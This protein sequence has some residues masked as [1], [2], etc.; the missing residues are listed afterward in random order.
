MSKIFNLILGLSI[1]MVVIIS[2]QVVLDAA[3]LG[4]EVN[5][6]EI[7]LS[8]VPL[9]EKIV[10]SKA[11]N[12]R[13]KLEIENKSTLACVYKIDILPASQTSAVIER[14]YTDI[15]DTSWIWPQEKEVMVQAKSTEEVELFLK[16]PDEE[17]YKGKNF[18]AV[19]EVKSK[20][21]SPEEIFV[22][23]VQLKIFFST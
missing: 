5:P 22:V 9:G 13:T 17:N 8:D 19:I 23:A 10:V 7:T 1:M 11:S 20:K 21:N 14:G 3:A 16:V 18:L 6:G 12:Q 2:P 15:P 4:V